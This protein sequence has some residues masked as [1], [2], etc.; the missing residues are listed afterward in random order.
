MNIEQAR[1]LLNAA[2]VFFD[3]DEDEPEM[4]QVLNMSDVW[5]WAC[6]D[7]EKVEDSELPEL[8]TL[9]FRYGWA[10]I[11]Y[12][13]SQKRGGIRSEFKDNNRFIDFVAHE[14]ELRKKIESSNQRAYATLTY[15]LGEETKPATI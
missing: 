8:G 4:R 13:V 14:E 3:C 15:T 7:C 6:A 9:F 10:G 11:L 1:T 2:D 5:A 12:W